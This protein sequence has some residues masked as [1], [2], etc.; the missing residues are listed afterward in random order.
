MEADTANPMEGIAA[1]HRSGHFSK[2][3]KHYTRRVLPMD[4]L[5]WMVV[6]GRGFVREKA[7]VPVEM[8]AGDIAVMRPGV[9]QEYWSD[10][11]SPWDL[12][13]VHFDGSACAKLVEQI[14]AFGGGGPTVHVGIDPK[15]RERFM[16]LVLLHEAWG[17]GMHPRVDCELLA[18]LSQIL[19]RLHR[20]AASGNDVRLDTGRVEAWVQER[21]TQKIVLGDMA[22]HVHLSEAHFC[23]LFRAAYG[24]SPMHYVIRLRM[25]RACHFLRETSSK[26]ADIAGA[27]G[28]GD[29]YYFSRLFAKFV[30]VSPRQFRE[31]KGSYLTMERKVS[32]QEVAF[33]DI[34]S[35][36]KQEA[37]E[38]Q[39]SSGAGEQGS[40]GWVADWKI[41]LRP[42][43]GK[44]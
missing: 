27:V 23:R 2:M 9:E 21:L 12:F 15:L 42:A 7:Q 14:R 26:V 17:A 31:G 28:Y 20:L 19:Q 8:G 33:D 1:L 18:L 25:G 30:G 11:T 29:P 44:K 3:P 22:K 37:V 24:E 5:V 6:D 10:A 4:Y 34:L 16:D 36:V 41:F 35:R 39:E 32:T 40:G 43:R 38:E 13:W